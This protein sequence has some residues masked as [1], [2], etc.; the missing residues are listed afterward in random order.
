MCVV[1]WCV[2]VVPRGLLC[3]YVCGS[4]V[5]VF[6]VVCVRCGRVMIRCFELFVRVHVCVVF[7]LVSAFVDFVCLCVFRLNELPLC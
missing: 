1:V 4:C 5:C 7:L 3:S 6:D 2:I